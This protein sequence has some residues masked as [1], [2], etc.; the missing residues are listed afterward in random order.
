MVRPLLFAAI[1]SHEDHSWSGLT[2]MYEAKYNTIENDKRSKISFPLQ[3]HLF[4][5]KKYLLSCFFFILSVFF[6]VSVSLLGNR[7]IHYSFLLYVISCS[8]LLYL[9]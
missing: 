5:K 2:Y 3:L 8:C 6:S 1:S 9:S 7:Q 4:F